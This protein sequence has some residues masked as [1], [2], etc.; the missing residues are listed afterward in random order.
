MTDNVFYINQY[1]SLISKIYQPDSGSKT[2]RF[3][4]CIP[5]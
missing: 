1:T 2:E 4:D 5:K 3:Y